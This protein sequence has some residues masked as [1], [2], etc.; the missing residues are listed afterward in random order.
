MNRS[1]ISTAIV[2]AMTA[3]LASGCGTKPATAVP[4]IKVGKTG[5]PTTS[6]AQQAALPAT[7]AGP[8]PAN[9]AVAKTGTLLLN[10]SSLKPTGDAAGIL[11]AIEI[12]LKGAGLEKPLTK[13]LSADE[14]K[15]SNTLAFENIPAGSLSATLTAFD[16]TGATLGVKSTAVEVKPDAESKSAFQLKLAPT[17]VGGK[18]MLAFDFEVHEGDLAP[19]APEPTRLSTPAGSVPAT[20]PATAVAEKGLGVEILNKETVRKYLIFKKLS[21]TVKVTNLNTS[22]SCSGEV[23]IEFHK[24][25]GFL[26]KEDK[27]VETQSLPVKSLAPGKSMELTV[28]SE[29]SAEDAEATVHTVLTSSS[30]ATWE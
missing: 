11:D 17:T 29:A 27:V 1:V 8:Q 9:Q 5:T 2:L 21:I 12:T 25:K 24:M 15:N 19:K 10:L 23:K 16:K 28:Q 30:V 20:T 26:S 7:K 18:A 22:E 6:A 4:A 14:V 13:R 3:V